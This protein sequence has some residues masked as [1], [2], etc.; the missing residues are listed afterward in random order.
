M[1]TVSLA[2]FRSQSKRQEARWKY[3]KMHAALLQF[4][5][6][7]GFKS[8]THTLTQ[9]CL[10]NISNNERIH[11]KFT[12]ISSTPISYNNFDWKQ[13]FAELMNNVNR[14][15]FIVRKVIK[16]NQNKRTNKNAR[17]DCNNFTKFPN[18]MSE[19]V[20]FNNHFVY[21]KQNK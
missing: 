8:H 5:I 20:F 7:V 16:S 1:L 12:L 18:M 19:L 3:S 21:V 11:T 14:R 4:S 17:N 2:F 10:V 13:L 6:Q 15:I 9:S